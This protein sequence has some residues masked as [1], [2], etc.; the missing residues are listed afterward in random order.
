MPYQSRHA[1]LVVLTTLVLAGAG[2]ASAADIMVP[3]D[4]ATIQAAIDLA[5]TGDRVLVAPGTYAERI[6]FLGKDI[7]VEATDGAEVTTIDGGGES[8]GAG[9]VVTLAG[10]ESRGAALRGFTITGG[11]GSGGSN[12]AGPGGG[13]LIDGGAPVVADCVVAGNS[14]ILGGGLSVGDGDPL[15][16]DLRLVDNTAISGGG[17]YVEGGSV[18]VVGSEFVENLARND[19][20][21]LCFRWNVDATLTDLLLEDNVSLQ[22]GSGM[23]VLGATLDASRIE[24]RGNGLIENGN[25]FRSF[26]GGGAYIKNTSGRLD[27]GRF[28]G[29]VSYAGGGVY[30]AGEMDDFVLVNS[31]IADNIV[32]LGEVYFNASSP[33]VTGCTVRTSDEEFGFAAFTT[34]NAEPTITNTAFASGYLGG[35]GTIFV[36]YSVVARESGVGVFGEGNVF[37]DA[38][39]DPAAGYAPLPGSPVIDAGDNLAVPAGATID[40]LGNDRFFDDPD[41]PD[42]GNGQA[43]IVDIGAI[44]FGSGSADADGDAITAVADTPAGLLAV[45]GAT[46]NPFNPRTEIRFTLARE[47]AVTVDVYDSRGRRLAEITPGVLD[48]GPHALTWDGTD[49]S[50]R[51]LAAGLYLAVVRAGGERQVAKMTLVR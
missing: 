46:P 11:F 12:G 27:R 25:V 19:G 43:P 37:G 38:L 45:A 50:D 48:A 30:L 39:L 28:T 32:G 5:Q 51:P 15:L 4:V 26:G 35:N 47:A 9:W 6:D 20:G 10:G 33:L 29:N 2:P 14:G 17:L 21:G 23:F 24:A 8:A 44:E 42:G 22:F 34:Y 36:D 1:I 31:L 7:V 41:T 16:S 3:D 40:L 18:E 13:I 49:R